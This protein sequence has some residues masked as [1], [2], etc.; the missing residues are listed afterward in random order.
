MGMNWVIKMPMSE[1]HN[2]KEILTVV[3]YGNGKEIQRIKTK[4][5][6]PLL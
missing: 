4:F 2:G 5:I 3:V 1:I 6:G